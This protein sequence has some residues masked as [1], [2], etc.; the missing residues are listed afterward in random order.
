MLWPQ[1][2]KINIEQNTQKVHATGRKVLPGMALKCIAKM[3]HL[4]GRRK[5]GGQFAKHVSRDL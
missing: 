3:V 4:Q 2:Q 5:T 1:L